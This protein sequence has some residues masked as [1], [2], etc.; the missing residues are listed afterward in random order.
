MLP[1]ID[2]P[3]YE[4]ELISTKQKIKIR[5]FL[6]KEQKLLLMVQE[7]ETVDKNSVITV[8]KQIINNCILSEIN[9]EELPLFDIEHIFLNL[10]ARSISEV[11]KLSYKCININEEGKNCDNLVKFDIDLLGIK[12]TVSKEHSNK[13]QINE[14]LGML[15]RYPRLN[16][17]GEVDYTDETKI[18]DLIMRCIDSIYDADTVYH[19]KD[20]S[21]EELEEFV[22]SL[23]ANAIEKIKLFFDTMPKIKTDL[24]FECG[25]CGYKEK[26]VLEGID[27][28]FV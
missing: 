9:V 24:D 12:P 7:S 28:F 8:I 4:L 11:V 26:I 10:R 21:K 13:I 17:F 6:V 18:L 20:T 3:I 2:V 23:P 19:T 5:P 16:M 22:D 15:M 14:T 1:K 25:K 27:S